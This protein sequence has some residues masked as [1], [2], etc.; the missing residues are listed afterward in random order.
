MNPTNLKILLS[1]RHTDTDTHI[2]HVSGPP[3]TETHERPRERRADSFYLL[4][5]QLVGPEDGEAL[6]GLLRG[7]TLR[8][9]SQVLEHLLDRYVLLR[10]RKNSIAAAEGSSVNRQE[11][12]KKIKNWCVENHTKRNKS[13]KNGAGKGEKKNNK[14]NQRSGATGKN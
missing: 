7:E 5:L 4:L 12:P 13:R 2:H 9:A 10:G 8:A 6:L 1:C 14:S 11:P 3:G